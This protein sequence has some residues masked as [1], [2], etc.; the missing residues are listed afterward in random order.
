MTKTYYNLWFL[1][2]NPNIMAKKTWEY[3]CP[4]RWEYYLS[5][6][7]KLAYRAP[8]DLGEPFWIAKLVKV[9]KRRIEIIEEEKEV[10]SCFW[11]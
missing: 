10:F 3:R 8:N 11:G 6:A 4:K 1:T 2:G 9:V 7:A 5:G